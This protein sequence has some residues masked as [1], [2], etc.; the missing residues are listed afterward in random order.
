VVESG[1]KLQTDRRWFPGH[2]SEGRDGTTVPAVLP[3]PASWLVSVIWARRKPTWAN[4]IPAGQHRDCPFLLRANIN[5]LDHT[6]NNLSNMKQNTDVAKGQFMDAGLRCRK[7]Q[8]DP[9]TRC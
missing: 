3:V 5:R 4:W 9:R 8:H 1:E 7:H 2:C 6:I